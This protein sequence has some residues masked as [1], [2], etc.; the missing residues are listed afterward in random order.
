MDDA[1]YTEDL[2]LAS[3]STRHEL[4]V[5]L[6]I[7]HIRADKPSTRALEARTRHY[8]NPLVPL[9]KTVVSEML[10]GA[11]FPRKSAMISFLRACG[12]HDDHVAPWTRAWE[13]IAER[14]N[15]PMRDS[16]PSVTP[17]R[18][19]NAERFV[20]KGQ[21]G[22]LRNMGPKTVSA[23]WP[24]AVDPQIE[25]LRDRLHRLDADNKR[26]RQQL[27]AFDQRAWW[28]SY[29][30]SY[31][32]YV[33]LE[34][35]AVAISAFQSAVV[36]GLLQ[37]ADYARVGGEAAL[38]RFSPE[39]IEMHIE[40]KLRRQGILLRDNP[41]R[42]A[43]ILDEAALHR[44]FGGYKAMAAQ[45]DKILDTSALPNVTVQVLPYEQGAHPALESNFTI[46]ELPDEAPGVVFVEGLIGS[47]YL[48]AAE[49]LE[50][51]QRYREVF[52]RLQSIAL[53]P[54]ETS[55]LISRLSQSYLAM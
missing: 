49:D 38:P 23:G 6:R 25:F 8:P 27:A 54:A 21:Q 51:Y 26:L 47:I 9:S 45:L 22:M 31:E 2:D 24:S 48:K 18:R 42:L 11:R 34:T 43:V 46:L 53:S 13:R 3:V 44:I 28:Q 20:D 5:L 50:R 16:A 29:H 32:D 55:G 37:T 17:V 35:E 14:E 10:S 30:L 52:G 1:P 36:H 39:R 33:G 40:A 7:V 19:G 4:A 12:V 41:P 15:E